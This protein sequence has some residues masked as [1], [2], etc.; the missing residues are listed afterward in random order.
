VE[1]TVA[2]QIDFSDVADPPVCSDINRRRMFA[3]RRKMKTQARMTA[4]FAT[5]IARIMKTLRFD[6]P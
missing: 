1:I 2:A 6:A 5:W 4:T 3:L